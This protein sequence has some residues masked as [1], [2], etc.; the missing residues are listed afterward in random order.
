MYTHTHL[1][2]IYL[3]F[4]LYLR[5]FSIVIVTSWAGERN[6]SIISVHNAIIS[7][8]Y[9]N[10]KPKSH[11]LFLLV[12]P[13]LTHC[14]FFVFT[15]LLTYLL[16]YLFLESGEGRAKGR[17]NINVREKHRLVAS[18]IYPDQRLNPQP[19][20]VPWLGIE[21]LTFHFAGWCPTKWATPVRARLSILTVSISKV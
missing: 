10:Q 13:H 20:H 14:Q 21:L 1:G 9:S 4:S 5:H 15:Y 11:S 18:R 16:T 17:E 2:S 7:C 12:T 8:I 3:L 6:T 19:R